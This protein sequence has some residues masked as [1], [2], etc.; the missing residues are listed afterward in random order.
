LSVEENTKK[1]L[2]SIIRG[3]SR[4]LKFEVRSKEK[5]C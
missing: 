4:C 3:I 2:K 1:S 5:C